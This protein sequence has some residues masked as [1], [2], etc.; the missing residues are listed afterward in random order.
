MTW[1]WSR[2]HLREPQRAFCDNVGF[3]CKNYKRVKAWPS[4]MWCQVQKTTRIWN[5]RDIYEL[6][7]LTEKALSENWQTL[8]C[9]RK[10][11]RGFVVTNRALQSEWD[12][13]LR[14][15]YQKSISEFKKT[16]VALSNWNSLKWN[17][18]R[19]RLECGC[20][21]GYEW[22]Q[23]EPESEANENDEYCSI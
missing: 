18:L 12:D 6:V 19:F 14:L 7:F 17:I 11:H 1:N 3:N 4:G 5:W 22:C 8:N 9:K 10:S 20:L 15:L 23:R 13:I 16:D 21:L 2:K